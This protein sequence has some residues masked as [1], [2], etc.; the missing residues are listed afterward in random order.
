VVLIPVALVRGNWKFM[1]KPMPWLALLGMALT[2]IAT[3]TIAFNFALV[4]ASATR[5]LWMIGAV[6][7]WAARGELTPPTSRGVKSTNSPS[8]G[9]NGRDATLT[10]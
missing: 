10:N 8:T 7:A 2:G 4:Y 3:F 6:I 9:V 5:A 1:P